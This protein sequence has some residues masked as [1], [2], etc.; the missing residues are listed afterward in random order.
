MMSRWLERLLAF[1]LVCAAFAYNQWQLSS[2]TGRFHRDV[3]TYVRQ[4]CESGNGLRATLRQEVRALV[5]IQF[6]GAAL[7]AFADRPCS[8]L[9]QQIKL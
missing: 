7:E 6:Q 8:T 3:Q 5:P 4:S 9:T 1:L 2:H